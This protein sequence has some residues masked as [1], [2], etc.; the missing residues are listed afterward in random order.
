[1]RDVKHQAVAARPNIYRSPQAGA[2]NVGEIKRTLSFGERLMASS[3]FRRCCF[4]IMLAAIWQAYGS[5]LNNDLLLPTFTSTIKAF[6]DAVVHGPLVMRTLFSLKVLLIGYSI[7]VVLAGI[8][9]SLAVA[10]RFGNDVLATLTAMFNPLPAIALLPLA[11]VWFGLG[12][13]SMAFVIVHSVL[14]AVALNTQ[15]GFQAV[16]ETQRMAGRNFG[17]RNLRYIFGILVPA[18]CPSILNGLKIGWA[19]AWRTLIAAELVFG[20]TSRSGGIGW[21]IFENR[22]SLEIANVFAGLLTVILIGLLIESIVFRTIER[23]SVQ[24]WGMQR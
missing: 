17:L 19:F 22:N 2:V 20:A 3:A 14:W 11:L 6:Y 10:T 5:Y 16:S 1:M 4:L 12:I 9:V 15:S 18:A 13:S 8:L 24:R 21:F 23:R 7:G